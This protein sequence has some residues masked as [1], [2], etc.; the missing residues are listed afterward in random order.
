VTNAVKT[1]F[2][3]NCNTQY[4]IA[5][6]WIPGEIV[7]WDARGWPLDWPL[8]KQMFSVVP[9]RHAKERR[10]SG[11]G[12]GFSYFQ[13]QDDDAKQRISVISNQS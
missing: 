2:I 1:I 7:F 4:S 3:V 8:K 11:T 12:R 13:N 9:A 10:S 5:K 6:A